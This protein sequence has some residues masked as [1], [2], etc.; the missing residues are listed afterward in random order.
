M[1]RRGRALRWLLAIVAAGLFV[2]AGGA[3]Y[4]LAGSQ[5]RL[6][7]LVRADV[8]A[9]VTLARDALGTV[10]VTGRDRR[11]VAWALGFVHGQERFFQMDLQRRVA[12]GELAALVGSAAVDSDMDHRRHR[13]RAVAVRALAQLPAGERALLDG[14]RDGVNA[15]LAAL[16]T[17]PWEYLL[18]HEQPA[19]WRSEDSLL[20]IGAMYLDLEADGN[21]AR[22]RAIAQM[23]DTLPDAVVALLLAPDGRWE[24]PLEGGAAS[25]P[26]VPSAAEVDFDTPAPAGTV[27]ET[28]RPGSNSFAVAGSLTTHGAAIVAGDMHLGLRVP[29]IWFRARLRYPDATA[30]GGIRDLNG[31]TLPGTPALVAGSNGRIAWAFTNSYGDWAD[32]VRVSIDPAHPDR[33]RTADGWAD[34]DVHHETILVH[35]GAARTLEVTD[36]RWGPVLAKD[37]DGTPLALAW[38]GQQPRAYNMALMQLEQA[39]DV[40]AALAVAPRAGMP[41]QNMLVGDDAGHI[42]W[43]LIG[44]AIPLRR[45]IDPLRPADWST[46]DTGWTDFIA[47]ADYPRLVD[48]T[49]GR[50]WTANNRVASGHAL[51]LLGDGGHDLGARAQQIADDLAQRARFAPG[52]M[53][54]IQLDDRAVFLTR[55]QQLLQA[56]LAHTDDPAL[57]QLRELTAA[58]HGTAATDSVDY[59]LVRAFRLQVRDAVL[60]PFI[61]RVRTQHPDFAFPSGT[62]GE[63]AVWALVQQ[64]PPHLLDPRYAD[65]PDLLRRAATAVVA[66]LGQQPGGLSARTWGEVNTTAI[67]HPLSRALPGILGRWLDM[68]AQAL[69]GDTN[70]P[71]VQAPAF[72]A[73]ERFGIMPG[74]EGDSYLM[75]PGGQSD[76]PLSPYHG[77]GH[78]DWA[79][80]RA[81]PLLPGAAEHTLTLQPS[82][83]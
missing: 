46:P 29:D 28:A 25:P 76:H 58:W 47:A 36:T 9:P 83:R 32:W 67:R 27:P 19:P 18:L 10:T 64:R 4:L 40:D 1:S 2:V 82:G 73:S 41:P 24:A 59:R 11:D 5:A 60:A 39:N 72:G 56:T 45:G 80:G 66:D 34:L 7:G 44:N 17:R 63:A 48:P 26:Y 23:H 57:I 81:T 54:A 42:G 74:H 79:A 3:W 70:M 30:P 77:A 78:A 49:D 37:V 69:P 21:N 8:A 22:E 20:S 53:L 31:V 6:D 15:G 68:P 16:R 35:G 33:Y 13:L 50:L 71:R 38:I 51:A 61:A 14:Y 75:M 12:A 55:W 52:D 43:T 62:D 65:W